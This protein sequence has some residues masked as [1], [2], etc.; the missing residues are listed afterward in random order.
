MKPLHVLTNGHRAS[1]Q[2]NMHLDGQVQLV[3]SAER[4]GQSVTVEGVGEVAVGVERAEGA[5][6]GRCWNYSTQARGCHST[7]HKRRRRRDCMSSDVDTKLPHHEAPPC[8][9]IQCLLLPGSPVAAVTLTLT[10]VPAWH[11]QHGAQQRAQ[12][13]HNT[14]LSG[15]CHHQLLCGLHCG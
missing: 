2:T 14:P 5:K 9:R 10:C 4:C 15:L 3:A 13:R 11:L 1:D 6:C 12:C 7:N 8:V